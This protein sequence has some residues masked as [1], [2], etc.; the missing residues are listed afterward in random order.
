MTSLTAQLGPS[1]LALRSQT[2][3]GTIITS[4]HAI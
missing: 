4:R 3:A 2:V 1:A